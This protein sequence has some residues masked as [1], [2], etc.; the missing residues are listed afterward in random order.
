[1][2]EQATDL[3]RQLDEAPM[4]R[5]QIIAIILCVLLNAL[6]GF[7]VLAISFASP[8]IAKEWGVDRAALGLVLSMEL[9]GMAVGSVLLGNV[10]DRIGRRPTIIFCLIVMA[11]GMGAA[12]QAWDV[13][14]LS[15]IRLATGLGIGGMLACT[16]AMVAE[17]ANARARSLAV[18][19]MAAGY[20]AGAILGGSVA[21][22]LLVAG[23]WRDI[24]LLGGIATALFLPFIWFLLPESIGFLLQKRPANALSRINDALGR[25]GQPL[26]NALPPVDAGA[27]KASFAALFAPGLARTTILLTLAYFCHI[28]TFYFILKWVPKIVV[29]MG[30]APSAAGGVLVWANVGGLLGAL[31]LSALSWRIA[32]RP[33]VIIAM[34]ASTCLVTLFGQEQTTLPGLSLI[35]AAAGF[36]TNGA[37]VGLYALV[38]QSFPTAVRAG[39]TGIVIGVGRGGAAL[40]PILAG[41]LFSLDVSLPWVAFAMALGSLIGAGLL[42]PLRPRPA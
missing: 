29:D 16:N 4:G 20:P 18:A 30:Y 7:D 13:I 14:S 28:M 1:M 15:I 26:I 22:Q 21:S 40:G 25:L 32:I 2:A 23:N 39:G 24:F 36:C 19:I 34:V 5:L 3:R 31:L 8:G 17:L 6:D 41:L 10:A 33:L 38:A 37:V 9:I 12:T 42:I 27:P 11:L 35:A